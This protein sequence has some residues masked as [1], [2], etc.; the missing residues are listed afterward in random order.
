[1][2]PKEAGEEVPM[3]DE[4][5]LDEVRRSG[6]GRGACMVSSSG[7]TAMRRGLGGFAGRR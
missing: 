7:D 6:G 2:F 1:M 3:L 5:G 4:S